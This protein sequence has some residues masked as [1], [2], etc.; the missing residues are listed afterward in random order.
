MQVP[1]GRSR[2]DPGGKQ[3]QGGA[4]GGVLGARPQAGETF[5]GRDPETA[6]AAAIC[7]DTPTRCQAHAAVPGGAA[8]A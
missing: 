8:G 5:H 7:Q 4:D 1:A 2:R 6:A 3:E